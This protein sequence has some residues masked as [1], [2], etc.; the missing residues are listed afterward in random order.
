MNGPKVTLG[1][2]RQAWRD[3]D[4]RYNDYRTRMEGANAGESPVIPD[5]LLAYGKATDKKVE[6]D[7]RRLM[8][9]NPE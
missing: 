3:Q 6:E 7:Y 5:D 9:R 8:G 4:P 2:V 1:A